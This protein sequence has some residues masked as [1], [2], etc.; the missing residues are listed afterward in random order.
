MGRP[1]KHYIEGYPSLAAFIAS[2]PDRTTLIFKRFDRLAARN[3]LHLQS[4]L[5]KLE[6]EQD[7]LDKRASAEDMQS[8]QCLRNWEDFSQAAGTDLRQKERLDLA[9]RIRKVLKEYR[10]LHTIHKDY[11][12]LLLTRIGEALIL[13]STLA[14][15]PEPSSKILKAFRRRFFNG[16]KG[17]EA[18]FPVLGGNS[19]KL[20]DDE[21][22]LVALKAEEQQDRLTTF[23]QDHL[24]FLFQVSK[25][26]SSDFFRMFLTMK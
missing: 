25:E 14:C 16:D 17:D 10:A 4:E 3:L 19:S 6:A 2:D 13:E 12:E 5:A 8:K 9:Q 22:D 7:A 1:E 15:F 20:F 24:A 21:H 26:F 11:L 23:A 18:S